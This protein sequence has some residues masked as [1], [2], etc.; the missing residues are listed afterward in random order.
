VVVEGW[1]EAGGLTGRFG[2][3]PIF[4]FPLGDRL[5]GLFGVDLLTSPG[6]YPLVVN[7]PDGPREADVMVRDQ[8]YGEMSRPEMG[9]PA[10]RDEAD[11]QAREARETARLP[12]ATAPRR[13]WEGAWT[14]PGSGR[15]VGAFGRLIRRGGRLDRTPHLGVDYAATAGSPVK[16]PADG[17]V[18]LAAFQVEDGGVVYLDHGLGLISRYAHLSEILV[19]PGRT[20]RRGDLLGRAGATGQAGGGPRLHYGLTLNGARIDPVA[21]HRLTA[22]LPKN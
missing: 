6:H 16:A 13:L 21:F 10:G 4:F 15:V 18:L 2:G 22:L 9:R 12:A 20:V 14:D 11:R 3:R 17:L 7:F 19:S 1:P 8:A 5:V